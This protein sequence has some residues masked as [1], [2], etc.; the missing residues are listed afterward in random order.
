MEYVSMVAYNSS[1]ILTWR[2]LTTSPIILL[3]PNQQ[4]RP[5]FHQHTSI[6]TCHKPYYSMRRMHCAAGYYKS[7]LIIFRTYYTEITS[8]HCI[9]LWF[10]N[11]ACIFAWGSY[12]YDE[13]T[14][15][16]YQFSTSLRFCAII[17]SYWHLISSRIFFRS[18]PGQELTSTLTSPVDW[19]L[20]Q[21]ISCKDNPDQLVQKEEK[22]SRVLWQVRA[23]HP[24]VSLYIL[25][26]FR[27]VT[28]PVC[29]ASSPLYTQIWW[30]N[31]RW[32]SS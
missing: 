27:T 31:H 3:C 9:Q 29:D 14:L 4:A 6:M 7:M 32:F 13:F 20:R 8:L 5:V 28:T 11:T 22:V 12:S 21:L 2:F 24:S 25:R 19:F 1:G 23:P 16:S 26:P 15:H 10:W 30:G 17:V 18:G